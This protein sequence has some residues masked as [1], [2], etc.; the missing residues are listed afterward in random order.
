MMMLMGFLV[1]LG[2]LMMIVVLLKDRW[3]TRALELNRLCLRKGEALN[4]DSLEYLDF[5]T[6]MLRYDEKGF[7]NSSQAGRSEN[8]SE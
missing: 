7:S 5:I 1:V 3:A 2:L 8:G 4:G 6:G